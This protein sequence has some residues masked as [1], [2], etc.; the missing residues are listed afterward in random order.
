MNFAR[1][2]LV[3]AAAGLLAL[4]ACDDPTGLS[5]PATPNAGRTPATVQGV[6]V[7]ENRWMTISDA[8]LWSYITQHDTAVVVGVKAPGTARGMYRAQRLVSDAVWQG[9]VKTLTTA[10]GGTVLNVDKVIPAVLI[11]VASVEQLRKLRAHPF[12]DYIEP[13]VLNSAGPVASAAPTLRAGL[14]PSEK[15]LS[16]SGSSGGDDNYGAYYLNGDSVPWIFNK[17]EIDQAWRRST[18]AG[19]TVGLID[20]GIDEYQ[21]VHQ[22][23]NFATRRVYSGEP[24]ID[25]HGHGTHQAGVL[26]AKRDGYHVVGVAYGSSPLSIKHSNSYFDVY[27]WRIAAALDTAVKYNAKVVQM[28]FRCEDQSNAVSDR[29]SL[30]Y[31]SPAYDVL[32]TAAV[33]SGGW[34]GQVIDGAIFPAVH[35]DVMAVSAIN[36]HTDTRYSGSHYSNKVEI[37]AYHGQPTVGAIVLGESEWETSGN[38]SNASTI[39]AGVATLVRSKY[40]WMRNYDVRYRLVSTARDIGPTGRDADS[41]YGLVMAMRAVGGMWNAE[42]LG[43]TV[44]GGGYNQSHTIDLTGNPLGGEGPFTYRWLGTL[45]GI[46]SRTVRVTV[47]QGDPTHHYSVEVTDHSDGSTKIAT[48]AIDPPL[49]NT[50]C[51]D[52]QVLVC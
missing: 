1:H 41:G 34:G 19:V 22:L 31:W 13:A 37:S 35:P 39:V 27:T 21:A 6:P 8:D 52:P 17:M 46:T 26:A 45:N 28:A 29:L 12:I 24:L 18:G 30:Y 42:I 15:R 16:S 49:G 23:S 10:H 38:S 33:G 50:T 51:E 3:P 40:P 9:A 48:A 14:R 44:S 2:L 5:T 32:F 4:A 36:Y 11:R 25:T 20:T 7:R 43:N 47:S